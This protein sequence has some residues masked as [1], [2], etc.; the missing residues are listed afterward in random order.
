MRMTVAAALVVERLSASYGRTQVLHS[1]DCGFGPGVTGLLGPN[2]AGKS[3]LFKV[4]TG[5]LRPSAGTVS[6]DGVV[7][8]SAAEWRRHME[9]LGYLPQ[10]PGWF[11]GFTVTELCVYMAGLRGMP[12]RRR[13]EAAAAAVAA[14]GLEAQAKTRLA[15][16]SGG[17]RRR[18]FLAQAIVHDP[19]L[20]ILDEPTSGL[21]PVQ[22]LN[23]R[24]LLAGLGRSRAVIMSTH[25]VE[26]VAHIAGSIV[27]LDKGRVVWRGDPAGLTHHAARRSADPELASLYERGFMA[28]LAEEATA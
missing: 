28:V 22:R 19:P 12:S 9:T 24:E 10:D 17:M 16:L 13:P 6:R 7:L 15:A 11:E 8:R 1:V 21:D 2:G 27:V 25:L 20:L 23:L 5:A 26:D 14:V 18:A 4:L 3:T